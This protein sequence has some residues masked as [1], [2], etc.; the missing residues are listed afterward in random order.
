MKKPTSSVW[1]YKPKTEK[2]KP[3]P[4][5]K[6]LSQTG[7]T[8]SNQF[9]PIFVLKNQTKPGQFEPVLVFY[10]QN[11]LSLVIFFNKNQ[12]KPDDILENEDTTGQSFQKAMFY[13][14][15]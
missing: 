10:L 2:T 8:K 6:K 9:E 4:N 15:I 13:Y 7:K 11:K 14:L 12:A 3:N 5:R 1:F